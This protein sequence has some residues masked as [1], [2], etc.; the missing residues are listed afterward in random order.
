MVHSGFLRP[1]RPETLFRTLLNEI[2]GES[3]LSREKAV[4]SRRYWRI[5]SN[6]RF[7]GSGEREFVSRFVRYIM[8]VRA[9]RAAGLGAG[10]E[11]LVDDRLD[12]T[13]TTAAFGAA[14]EAA[15]NLLGMTRE[16]RCCVNG[17]ADVM[18]AQNVT[19]TND[20]EVGRPIGDAYR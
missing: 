2:R 17:I 1:N 8:A 9:A 11:R 15:V 19:G 14:A 20:H 6:Q 7:S 5:Q 12:G 13:G 3:N 18:V 4:R 16:I 10:A